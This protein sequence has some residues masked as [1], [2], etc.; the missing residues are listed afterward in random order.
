MFRVIIVGFL[1]AI[2]FFSFYGWG[3]LIEQITRIR[4]PAPF[5]VGLGMACVIFV[6]GCLNLFGIALPLLLDITIFL[7]LVNTTRAFIRSWKAK[8]LIN[9]SKRYLSL[10]YLTRA[11]PSTVLI[12][13]VFI[14]STYTQAPPKAFNLHDDFEKYLSHPVRMLT[15]GSL[16]GSQF[17]ALG[18]ETLGGQALLQGF[19]VAHWPIG[20][21]L[22]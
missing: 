5:T 18:T 10:D 12:A 11:V 1:A 13:I 14:F 19:A 4:F 6:G 20:Y 9:E 2:Y 7:G 22:L 8:S 21:L 3:H 17:N 16:K 15:T